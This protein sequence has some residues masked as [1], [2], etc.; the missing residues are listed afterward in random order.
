MGAHLLTPIVDQHLDLVFLFRE[1]QIHPIVAENQQLLAATDKEIDELIPDDALCL[2]LSYRIFEQV[3]A[4]ASLE[5]AT[6]HNLCHGNEFISKVLR[7]AY[8]QKFFERQFGRRRSTSKTEPAPE[9]SSTI[10]TRYETNKLIERIGYWVP[11][12]EFDPQ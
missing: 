5:N 1:E 8:S 7:S 12:G 10:A 2:M 9:K 4:G 6:V 11:P 3:V